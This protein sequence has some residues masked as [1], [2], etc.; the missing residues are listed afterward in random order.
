MRR[1]VW[2]V[3]AGRLPVG[4]LL[5]ATLVACDDAGPEPQQM[6]ADAAAHDAAIDARVIDAAVIDAALTD[7]GADLM[8][9]AAPAD[10]AAPDATPVDRG[11]DAAADMAAPDMHADMAAPDM[12]APDMAAPDRCARWAEVA[13]DALVAAIHAEQVATYAPIVPEVD[14]GG[15]LNRYTT[16]RHFMF[17]QVERVLRGDGVEGVYTGRFVATGPDEEPDNDDIN[18]EHVWPRAR[19]DPNEDGALYEHQQ[20]DV[21]ILYPSDSDANSTRGSNRY[22]VVTADRNLDFLPSVSGLNA[23]G[24]RVFEPR[25]ARKGDIARAVLYFSI[26]WGR[27]IEATEQGVLRQWVV[28]DPVD[29]R[30]RQRNTLVEAVQGNRNPFVD[31]PALVPRVADFGDFM[32]ADRDLPLP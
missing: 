30:E 6:R 12:A 8:H 26:R 27:G 16:A 7:A 32:P 15:N 25:D 19:M 3:G 20:S 21:H 10:M 17:T 13:D 22:G 18:A 23:Q 4:L 1:W 28:S 5:L 31:C 2:M 9:D 11:L 14:R 29:D 24:D